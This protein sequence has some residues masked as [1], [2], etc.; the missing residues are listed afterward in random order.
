MIKKQLAIAAT[1]ALAIAGSGAA[2]AGVLEYANNFSA[3]FAF[4]DFTNGD[5]VTTLTFSNISGNLEFNIPSTGGT[6]G[7]WR[8]GEFDVDYNGTGT[9]SPFGSAANTACGLA[10]KAGWDFC[11]KTN[12]FVGLGSGT[13]SFTGISGSKFI[14]NW[15]TDTFTSDGTPYTVGD[16]SGNSVGISMLLGM[17]LGPV[18]GFISTHIGDGTLFV[19]QVFDGAA[20]SWTLTLTETAGVGLENVL[21]ALD[22]GA[23]IPGLGVLNNGLIDGQVFANGVVHIPEPASMALVGLGLAGMAALRRRKSA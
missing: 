9:P 11:S 14:Y 12:T 21:K 10:G 1:A 18:G 23:A 8:K 7:A 16:F 2:N 17:F 22:S 13:F 6:F 3:N 5:N 19:H 20:N 4:S 15:D